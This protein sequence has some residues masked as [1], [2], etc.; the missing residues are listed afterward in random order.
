MGFDPSLPVPVRR[1]SSYQS[2]TM[3]QAQAQA[4]GM[5]AQGGQGGQGGHYNH[6]SRSEMDM[7]NRYGN[8]NNN[9]GHSGQS[10]NSGSL[11]ARTNYS[12]SSFYEQASGYNSPRSL[13]PDYPPSEYP[14]YPRSGRGLGYSGSSGDPHSARSAQYEQNQSGF[15]S[16]RSDQT[17]GDR[18]GRYYGGNNQGGMSNNSST[19]NSLHLH[20]DYQQDASAPLSARST[21]SDYQEGVG[22]LG[23]A[24]NPPLDLSLS[25]GIPEGRRKAP[26]VP[27]IPL[28]G[29]GLHGGM[30][31]DQT[32][33]SPPTLSDSLLGIREFAPELLRGSSAVFVPSLGLT[34][35]AGG[36]QGLLPTGR[37]MGGGGSFLGAGVADTGTGVMGTGNAMG[38]GGLGD[39][40]LTE[41]DSGRR[42][43][44]L[45]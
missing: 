8:N 42:G 28:A 34:G 22:A 2:L 18:G 35:G 23:G 24:E 36:Y 12:G 1:H 33:L 29:L 31:E 40:D 30:Y 41:M 38:L 16:A 7:A 44:G 13:N 9:H 21:Y 5:Q 43:G 14:D 45:S 32:L 11:S 20:E 39:V 26:V 17:F 15:S 25:L 10:Y 3:A 19:R 4:M 37:G 6:L 27:M